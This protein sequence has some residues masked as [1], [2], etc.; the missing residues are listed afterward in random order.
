MSNSKNQVVKRRLGTGPRRYSFFAPAPGGAAHVL[1]SE[2]VGLGIEDAVD[3]GA[4]VDFSGTLEHGYRALLW[5]RVA[6]RVLAVI[7]TFQAR[8]TDELYEGAMDVEWELHL[9]EDTTFSVDANLGKTAITHSKYAALRVKDA[10]ADRF[11]RLY[12][13][14]PSVDVKNPGIRLNVHVHK[15]LATLYVDLA[16]EALHRRGYRDATHAAP[17]KENLAAAVLLLA[18]WPEIARTGAPLVDPMCGLGTFL[19]EGGLMAANVAP[20]LLRGHYGSPEWMLHEKRV[21]MQLVDEA[22][23]AAEDGLDNMPPLLGADADPAAVEAARI[24]L[25]K[26]GLTQAAR[27]ECATVEDAGRMAANDAAPGLVVCNP[28]YGERLGEVR[29]LAELYSAL[30]K[31][32][33]RQYPGWRASMLAPNPDLGR[34]TGLSAHKTHMLYNGPL[35]CLLLHFDIREQQP[36]SVEDDREH[37][38]EEEK[39]GMFANRLGKNL[40]SLGKWARKNDVCCFRA[41]DADMPEYN[42][43]VDVFTGES[44][45]RWAHVR[46]YPPP[47][48]MDPL[49]TGSRLVA[50]LGALPGV[51]DIPR[52]NVF[53]K[54]KLGG[55]GTMAETPEATGRFHAV[56]EG[57]CRYLVN[58]TDYLDTG[59]PLHL[60]EVRARIRELAKGRDVLCLWGANGTPAVSAA[61]GSARS[62]MVVEPSP[63]HAKWA[64]RNFEANRMRGK[65]HRIVRE[66]PLEW[67]DKAEHD[68]SGRFGLVVVHA[69]TFFRGSGQKASGLAAD[70]ARLAV[71]ASALLA[72]NGILL[73][74]TTYGRPILDAALL[75]GLDARDVTDQTIPRDFART[76][77][78][79][80]CLE[81]RRR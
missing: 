1:A 76:P 78:V 62:T 25:R 69:P 10:V 9:S 37:E 44:G 32:F 79:H 30:G 66:D 11:R 75:E 65:F 42:V 68:G 55:P 36:D 50:S 39:A 2:L 49:A 18:G 48:N 6:T 67:L 23:L 72:E 73:Y 63:R 54:E 8:D 40:K 13:K 45:G 33:R 71:R 41:Y 5:S 15:D 70:H 21:W 12:G 22:D 26:A 16:G 27:L 56:V 52:E 3:R 60:R 80:Q 57:G 64:E 28:P 81:I 58:F 77:G 38:V 47:V 61:G 20:G 59:L 31:L 17:L 24:C 43:S 34:Q 46:E 53:L 51:L 14:R 35:K 7:A 29:E 74:I 4:G 19:V